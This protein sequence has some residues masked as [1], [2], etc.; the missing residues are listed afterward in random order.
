MS[1]VQKSSV[2]QLAWYRLRLL[3]CIGPMQASAEGLMSNRVNKWQETGIPL[4]K[5]II[6]NREGLPEGSDP[7]GFEES[8]DY[9]ALGG[10]R[11]PELH[12]PVN[13]A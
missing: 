6:V 11:F 5:H 8:E 1:R 4:P 9:V 13:S 7:A 10:A 2:L 3:C 12:Q